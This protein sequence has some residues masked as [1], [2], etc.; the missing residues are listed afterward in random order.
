MAKG[1]YRK[2]AIEYKKYHWKGKAL[3]LAGMPAWLITSVSFIFLSILI[4]TLFFCSYTQRIDVRG[5]VITLPHSINVFSPQQGFIVQQYV[6]T[7]DIVKKGTPLYELDISRHTANGNVS[8][9][10]SEVI[11]EKIINAEEII[12]KIAQNK[13]ETLEAL[14]EQ[15]RQFNNSLKETTKMLANTQSGLKKM[16]DNLA[17]YDLYLRQGLI[18]K[19][20]YNYQHSLYFQQQSTYQSLVSQKMQQES[21]LTQLKSD[22]V[23]KAADFDN[24]ISSQKNN[25]ND[26]KNQMVETNANGNVIIKA[27]NDGK[28]ESMA[29]TNG[30]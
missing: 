10:I 29:V 1:I 28:I 14:N 27:T 26:F 15:V 20:Q 3:L 12:K 4:L 17:S 23:T 18:T 22:I 6:K 8:D 11:T 21:Q 7:G 16:K 24:Q 25:I 2:E 19:D 13:K 30:Q 5:E 9:A